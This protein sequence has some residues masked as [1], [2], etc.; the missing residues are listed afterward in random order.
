MVLAPSVVSIGVFFR[1]GLIDAVWGVE[2]EDGRAAD[3]DDGRLPLS[4][5]SRRT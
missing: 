2:L 3:P 4:D 5:T 1:A